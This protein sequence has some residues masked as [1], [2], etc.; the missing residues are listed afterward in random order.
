MQRVSTSATLILKFFIPTFWI[1]FFGLFLGGMFVVDFESLGSIPALY[2]KVIAS[3]LYFSILL[4]FWMTIMS[5]KRMEMDEEY[6]YVTNYF[7]TFRYSYPSIEKV[8]QGDYIFFKT[9]S[10]HFKESGSFG[11]KVTCIQSQKLFGDF[12]KDHPRIA[13]GLKIKPDFEN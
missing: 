3:V 9:L 13:L 7:K 8:S 12:I 6:L 11:K 1:I 10:F 4:L 5:L 2:I